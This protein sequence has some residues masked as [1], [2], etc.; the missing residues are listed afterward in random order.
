M[1]LHKHAAGRLRPCPRK[2]ASPKT[3]ELGSLILYVSA[4]EL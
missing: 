4:P 3:R 1:S 2:P